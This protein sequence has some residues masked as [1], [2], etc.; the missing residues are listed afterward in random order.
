MKIEVGA[1]SICNS[2]ILSMS[3]SYE[4]CLWPFNVVHDG[5]WV[6][7]MS[8]FIYHEDMWDCNCSGSKLTA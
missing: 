4:K 1:G 5:P 8:S 2:Y 6:L 7:V 3:F